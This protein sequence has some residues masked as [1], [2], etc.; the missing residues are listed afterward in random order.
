MDREAKIQ[1]LLTGV[2]RLCSEFTHHVPPG[3]MQIDELLK[4]VKEIRDG[5]K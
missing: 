1:E 2:E 3:T 5:G 4:L